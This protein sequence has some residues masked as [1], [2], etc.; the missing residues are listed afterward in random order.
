MYGWTQGLRPP[1][2]LPV[3]DDVHRL[4]R[5]KEYFLCLY[6]VSQR[7]NSKK[8]HPTGIADKDITDIHGSILIQHP[9]PFPY[10]RQNKREFLPLAKQQ[11]RLISNFNQ[12]VDISLYG[13]IP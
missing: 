4:I 3:Q 11:S 6:S 7:T 5:T 13:Q 10:N 8:A 1:M 9:A 2:I 12:E